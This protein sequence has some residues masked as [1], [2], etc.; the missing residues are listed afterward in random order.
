ML[1]KYDAY[2]HYKQYT[3][4]TALTLK[5]PHILQKHTHYKLHTHTHTYT[6][7]IKTKPRINTVYTKHSKQS[8]ID[9]TCIQHTPTTYRRQQASK[10]PCICKHHNI[11][12]QLLG[13]TGLGPTRWSVCVCVGL[14]NYVCVCVCL[15][16]L[17]Q[18]C[19]CVCITPECSDVAFGQHQH[20]CL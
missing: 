14:H 10:W 2:S 15:C 12:V 17:T 5:T 6:S 4:Q 13:K 16:G 9:N 3:V 1:I 18:R 19:V 7:T 11:L 8:H 20:L